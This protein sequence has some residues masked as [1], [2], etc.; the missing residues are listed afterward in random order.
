M[1]TL[2]KY[3]L[4]ALLGVFQLFVTP[5][6]LAQGMAGDV[7]IKEFPLSGN[8]LFAKDSLVSY[9]FNL[10][11]NYRI[12]QE[13]TL[14]YSITTPHGKFLTKSAIKVSLD[15]L[16]S[17]IVR[18]DMP[19]QKTGFYKVNFMLNVSDYDDTIRRVFG[20]DV[21]HIRS[22]YAKPADFDA[23]WKQTKLALAAIPPKFKIIPKPSLSSDNDDIYLVEM[24]S[25]GNITVR[26]WLTLPKD[27]KPDEK[28][29]AYIMLPGYGAEMVPFRGVP[30]FACLSLNVRG[31]GNSK[32]IVKPTRDQYI[33]EGIEDKNK[34]IYRG[35]LMDCVRLLDFV[36]ARP[37]FDTTSVFVTGG[38]MGAYLALAL[39]GIDSRVT[40][41]C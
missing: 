31:L 24:Q 22:E 41:C 13:G 33:T 9:N 28:L 36:N 35:A 27:R 25:L 8:A 1:F 11:N 17:N 2:K 23:F 3:W 18:L 19:T 37:E 7:L 30:H 14:S 26:A 40:L 10:K 38:S 34:Y 20:V 32:D 4:L 16:S 12:K 39:A 29:P 5:P 21:N 6:I 15:P